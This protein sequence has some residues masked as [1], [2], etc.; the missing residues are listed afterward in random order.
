MDVVLDKDL[1]DFVESLGKEVEEEAGSLQVSIGENEEEEKDTDV[2]S[3]IA[4]ALNNW[5]QRILDTESLHNI[6]ENFRQTIEDS[7]YKQQLDGLLSFHDIAEL[8]YITDVWIKLLNAI[9]C[10]GVCCEFV[11]R[12]IITLLLELYSLKQLTSRL[13]IETCLKL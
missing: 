11:K 13:F 1:F 9:S 6:L 3:D 2:W 7:L 5:S 8:R 4:D 10:Y 12:E